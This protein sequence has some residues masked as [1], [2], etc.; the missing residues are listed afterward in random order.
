[1]SSTGVDVAKDDTAPRRHL[2]A[3]GA[4]ARTAAGQPVKCPGNYSP[5][6]EVGQR[7]GRGVV[8]NPEVRDRR[9]ALVTELHDEQ[10]MSVRRISDAIGW[11]KSHVQRLLD[12]ES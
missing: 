3:T 8:I 6:P 2:S 7:F 5:T 4:G 11:S 1:M 10:G 12:E 9:R